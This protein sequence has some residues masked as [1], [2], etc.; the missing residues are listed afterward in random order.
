MSHPSES[1]T[2]A[3]MRIA[4]DG[5]ALRHQAISANIANANLPGH[6]PLA[7]SFEAQLVQARERLLG[8]EPLQSVLADTSPAVE[9][10]DAAA[11]GPVSLDMQVA[12]MAQNVVHHQALLK[13]WNKRMSILSTAINDGRR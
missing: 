5:A 11:S 6:R 12:D 10:H 7:V 9:A 3:I 8:G 13:G 2:S 4:L 1:A